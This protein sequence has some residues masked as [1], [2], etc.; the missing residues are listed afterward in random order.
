MKTIN[1]TYV[2]K[3]T[4]KEIWRALVDPDHIE[5]WSG[6]K[7]KM[8]DKQGVPFELWDGDIYGTNL[9]VVTNKKLVQEWYG[10]DWDK[11]SKVTFVLTALGPEQTQV[12]LLHE[13]VPDKEA[14]DIEDGW[15][16]YYLGEIKKYLEQ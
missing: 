2:I 11:P 7:A 4:P 12:A 14:H 6:G 8:S 16:R 13:N 10:G 15:K 9:E 3:A 1:Q 5:V